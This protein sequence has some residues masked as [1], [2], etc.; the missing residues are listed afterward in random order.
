MAHRR[1]LT[2]GRT[3]LDDNSD[4]Y[5]IAEIGHNHQGNVKKARDMFLATK[6]C[7]ANAV[8]LQKRNNKALY[9]RAMYD[10]PYN[11]ENAYAPTYGTHRD[12]LELPEPAFLELRALARELGLHFFATAFD[13]SSLEFGGDFIALPLEPLPRYVVGAS[14]A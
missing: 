11:S 1:N 7:G 13:F 8:K 12:A 2:I 10:S 6:E 4:C 5:V 14:G 9:T 3:I